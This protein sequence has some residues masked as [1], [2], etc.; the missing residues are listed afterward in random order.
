M[1]AKLEPCGLGKKTIDLF[2][3][4][5]S[6]EDLSRGDLLFYFFCTFCITIQTNRKPFKVFMNFFLSKNINQ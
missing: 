6:R 2:R 5:L 3:E 1:C 4:D